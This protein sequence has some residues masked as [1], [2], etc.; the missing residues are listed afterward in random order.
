MDRN[1]IY[2]LFL[3]LCRY[4]NWTDDD[5]RRMR[6]IAARLATKIE[7]LV[8]DFYAEIERH[9][10]TRKVIT[11]GPEQVAQLHKTLTRWLEEFFVGPYDLDYV[12]RRW[13][14]GHRH[15]EIG[16]DQ[17]YMIAALSRLRQ[18]LTRGLIGAARDGWLSSQSEQ[19]RGTVAEHIATLNKLLD[20]DLAII[21][22]SYQRESVAREQQAES[23]RSADAIRQE[24]DFAESLIDT[25]HAIVLVLDARGRIV[26]FNAYMEALC[27][28]KLDE[29]RGKDWFDMFLAPADRPGVQKVF[30]AAAR[31]IPTAG[32]VHPIVTRDGQSRQIAWWD[33]TLRDGSDNIVG[34]LAI[35]HDVT[36]LKEAETQ[37]VQAERLA[38]VGKAI[39]S[40]AHESRNALQRSQACLEMLSRRVAD[41]P[42]AVDLVN[43]VQGAQD[44]LSRLYEEVRLYAAPVRLSIDHW[45]MDEIVAEAWDHLTHSK[46]GRSVQLRQHV[47]R[48]DTRCHAD[49][50]AMHQVFRNILENALSLCDDPVH[51]DVAY[52]GILL[53]GRDALQIVLRDNGPGLTRDVQQ[54]MFD[55]FYTTKTQG[56]GLG[57]AIVKRL[58]EAHSGQV[59][60]RSPAGQGAEIIITLPRE[61][62]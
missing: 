54:H 16:L 1:R 17:S 34:I 25:A 5:A 59:A 47:D 29:V 46:L 21:Q 7:P 41:R 44:D 45:R 39:T 27:G 50:F 42:E 48:A 30:D 51:I 60:A 8:D 33:K 37:L 6:S 3:D 58:V 31:G 43:R 9:A 12:L 52:Q 56:T 10:E 57:L 14:V 28:Y 18:G 36:E 49:R 62:P 19:K 4:V 32:N 23:K 24:R 15:V 26:R 53:D 35:G 22:D 38:A 11:G 61:A 40:L 13:K 55:E 20:L 2:A